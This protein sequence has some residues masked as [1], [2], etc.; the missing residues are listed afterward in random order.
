MVRKY[1]SRAQGDWISQQ[2]K[3]SGIG[4]KR[5][6]LSRKSFPTEPIAFYDIFMFAVGKDMINNI[7]KITIFIER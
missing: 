5:I 2:E 7:Q 1:L 4:L 6:P 3:S